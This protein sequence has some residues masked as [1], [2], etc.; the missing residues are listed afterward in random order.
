[1]GRGADFIIKNDGT[2]EYEIGFENTGDMVCSG[3]SYFDPLSG[4]LLGGQEKRSYLEVRSGSVLDWFPTA[5]FA[6]VIRDRD[7]N[8]AG[9][10]GF[11]AHAMKY[12]LTSSETHSDALDISVD[13]DSSPGDPNRDQVTITLREGVE[14]LGGLPA[15]R[16]PFG[17][18]GRVLSSRVVERIVKGIGEQR[19]TDFLVFCHGINNSPAEAIGIYRGYFAELNQVNGAQRTD[20]RIGAAAVLWPTKVT[21]AEDGPVA[22]VVNKTGYAPALANTVSVGA[23]LSR[24]VQA[25]RAALAASGLDTKIHL[26]AHSL[27]TVMV[28]EAMAVLSRTPGGPWTSSAFLIQSPMPSATYLFPKPG[29]TGAVH[30]PVAA[31]CS[32]KDSLIRNLGIG[33]GY[34]GV[35]ILGEVG[36]DPGEHVGLLA[37]Q[38]GKRVS[39]GDYSRPFTTVNCDARDGKDAV[40]GDHND[41]RNADVARA[42]LAAMGIG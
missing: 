38:K 30:G 13:L 7:G 23:G 33:L 36:F 16:V 28:T 42:H 37:M 9:R 26:A 34:A 22:W 2:Q 40:I 1:M 3:G 11:Y 14:Y 20:R 21:Y 29:G 6:M 4:R 39:P 25:L 5:H 12:E 18:D 41:F 27:G 10:I 24:F 32:T 35:R 31:T 19:I 15:W 8:V 17:D